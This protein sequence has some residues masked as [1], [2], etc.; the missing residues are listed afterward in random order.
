MQ[1]YVLKISYDG[2]NYSGFQIQKDKV[3]IQGELE[4]AL[5]QVLKSD[6][7]IVASGRTDA[8]VSAIC[9]VCHFDCNEDINEHRTLSYLNA[10][11]PKDIRVLEI[12]KCS[13]DFHARYSSKQKTYEYYFYC[14]MQ[15]AVYERFATQIGLNVNIEA[16]GEA[17]KYFEGEHDFSSFC[18]SNTEV[19]DKVRIVY[20]C[21]IVDL[22][23]G[24]YKLVITGNGFLY[25]M[26]R[27]IMGTL[28]D[29]G[30]GKLQCEKLKDVIESKSRDQAGKTMPSKGLVLKNVEY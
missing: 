11:L 26:V 30:Y 18:A 24:L 25:N 9:Q 21:S 22:G 29:V 1:R 10:I 2:A 23:G 3:T 16:M 28:V 15:N 17:C 8:G 12:D 27:I 14:G 20:F 6:I 19:K 4:S 5:K 13:S 7:D